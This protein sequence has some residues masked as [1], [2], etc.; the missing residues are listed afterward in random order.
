MS[1]I[2]QQF[3]S[4]LVYDPLRHCPAEDFF[5]LD[6]TGSDSTYITSSN[7]SWIA[8]LDDTGTVTFGINL[9][10][11]TSSGS[12]QLDAQATMINITATI[13]P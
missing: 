9:D 13:L 5:S 7:T 11:G 4:C 6:V 10:L 3:P 8:D 12:G 1:L 2:F